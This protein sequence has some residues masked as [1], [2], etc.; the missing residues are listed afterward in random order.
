MCSGYSAAVYRRGSINEGDAVQPGRCAKEL[1]RPFWFCAE[2]STFAVTETQF[3]PLGV[4]NAEIKSSHISECTFFFF[5]Q[6]QCILQ[7]CRF[8]EITTENYD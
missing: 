1:T 5:L 4:G 8:S 6:Y 7:Y 2:C 3:Q